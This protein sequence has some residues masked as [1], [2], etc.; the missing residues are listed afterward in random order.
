MINNGSN[1][2]SDIKKKKPTKPGEKGS[3]LIMVMIAVVLLFVV[4]GGLLN[5]GLLSQLTAAHTTL[6][7]QARCAVDSALVEAIFEMNEKLETVPW[8]DTFLPEATGKSLPNC[9]ATYSYTV[10]GDIDS[11]YFVDAVGMSGNS[12]RRVTAKLR[13]KSPFESAVFANE[14]IIMNSSA[15]V[16]YS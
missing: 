14:N 13:L 4:G 11:G 12:T 8:D 5:L 1:M 7:I 16:N 6:E 15:L 10:T 3:A 2:S 9:E